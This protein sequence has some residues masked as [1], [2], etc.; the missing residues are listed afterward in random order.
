MKKQSLAILGRWPTDKSVIL[1]IFLSGLL[2]IVPCGMMAGCGS[3]GGSGGTTT[4]TLETKPT[5]VAAGS[6]TVFTAIIVHNHGNF[7]GANWSLTSNG[8]ACSP[9]CGSLSN[10]TNSGSSG[11][12]DT[13]TITYTAPNSF[14]SPITITAA[15]VENPSSTDSDTFTVTG[16]SEASLV[17]ATTVLAGGAVNAIYL[18]PPLAATGGTPPYAW[19]LQSAAATFPPGLTLNA[20]GSISGT[21]SS[22]NTYNFTVQVNDSASQTETAKLSIRVSAAGTANVYAGVSSP[23]DVWQFETNSAL[24][25]FTAINLTTG[26]RYTGTTSTQL[27]P[28]GWTQTTLTASTDPNLSV[29]ATGFGL[30]VRGVGATF[31]LGGQTDNPV[32]LIPLGACPTISGTATMQY[33]HLGKPDYDATSSEAYGTATVTQTGST[34]NVSANSYLLDGT[35]RTSQSGALPAGSCSNGVITIPNVPTSSGGTTTVTVVPASN[36]LYLI[37]LGPGH[38]SAIG[39]QTFVGM[40]ELNTG[41]A[42]GFNGYVFQR[43]AVASSPRTTFVGF[44]PG[45]GSS[46]TGGVYANMTTDPFSNHGTDTTINFQQANANGFLQGTVMDAAGTHDPFIGIVSSNDG[47]Y[48]IFGLTS[49]FSSGSLSSTQPYVMML[50]QH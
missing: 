19:S 36:G 7:E 20:D 40:T 12:G 47:K 35:L 10:H 28:N 16:Q 50:I 39:T 2:G 14:A 17:V 43:N 5:S 33:V 24:N 27:L 49:D 8:T 18:T 41:L 25:Q 44:G 37:A 9:G 32:V 6:Q 34:Y 3:G 23:G 22:S 11:N 46:I 38:G 30:E 4:L 42:N 48:F 1:A 45:S 31:A 29:G 15:S 21:P 26:T 13:D